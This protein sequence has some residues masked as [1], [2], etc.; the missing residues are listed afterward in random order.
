MNQ[1]MDLQG[2]NDETQMRQR[3]QALLSRARQQGAAA[4]IIQIQS[5]KLNG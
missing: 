2:E 4:V 3:L 5:A 1:T